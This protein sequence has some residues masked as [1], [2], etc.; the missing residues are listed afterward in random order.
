MEELLTLKELLVCGDIPAAMVLVEEMTEMSK[1][2]KISKIFSYSIILLVHLIK[3]KAE[4]RTTRSWDLSIYNSTTQIRRANQ[5]RKAKGTYLSKLEL[6]ETL[7]EAYNIALASAA[8]EAFEGR[9][10][11]DELAAMCD[12]DEILADALKLI[13][14]ESVN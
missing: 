6:S 10:E 12:H 11:A 8:I 3:Q 1:D 7:A 4:K 14:Q 9:Y 13:E 5:R 2:D